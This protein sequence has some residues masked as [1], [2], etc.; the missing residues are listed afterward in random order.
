MSTVGVVVVGVV[1]L[2]RVV[3]V[4]RVVG[5]VRL[6]RLVAVVVGSRAGTRSFR[7]RGDRDRAL[8]PVRS[9][10]PGLSYLS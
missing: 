8:A 9:R 1:R 7:D 2:V 5:A 3:G 4:V 10:D 6:V